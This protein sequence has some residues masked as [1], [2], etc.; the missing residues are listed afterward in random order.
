MKFSEISQEDWESLRD[1]LDTC[2]LP[3]TG[4]SGGEDPPAVTAMLERLRDRLEPIESAYKGRIVTYPA[5]HFTGVS[6]IGPH[7]RQRKERHLEA[8]ELIN[9]L[10]AT[11]KNGLFRYVVLIAVPGSV[12]A[13]WDA[14]RFPD[15]DL[16]LFGH[17]EEI[18][19]E[20]VKLW[21]H[22]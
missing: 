6:D 13:A 21:Q 2:L 15:S 17:E 1:Y 4:L 22:S 12:P 3:I 11:L 7:D 18:K 5:F 8:E 16:C 9:R 20:I 14:E 19:R 10:C